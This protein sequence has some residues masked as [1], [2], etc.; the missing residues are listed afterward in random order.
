MVDDLI[1]KNWPTEWVNPHL[2]GVARPRRA[3]E[4]K[5]DRRVRLGRPMNRDVPALLRPEGFDDPRPSEGHKSFFGQLGSLLVGSMQ[6]PGSSHSPG[7][8]ARG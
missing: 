1:P 4:F 6:T 8:G 2:I 3:L 5:T 7:V